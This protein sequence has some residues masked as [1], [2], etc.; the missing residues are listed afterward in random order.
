M[1]SRCWRKK[2][3]GWF[4]GTWDGQ[5]EFKSK[6]WRTISREILIRQPFHLDNQSCHIFFFHITDDS[7]KA[8]FWSFGH[9]TKWIMS[10]QREDFQTFFLK[11]KSDLIIWGPFPLYLY[12]MAPNWWNSTRQKNCDPC[13]SYG[14]ILRKILKNYI[15]RNIDERSMRAG[16][17]S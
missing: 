16:L 6:L 12:W 11:T 17:T 2:Y 5:G 10:D 3:F 15:S 14:R 1:K 9:G 13:L 7:E 8:K 4:F